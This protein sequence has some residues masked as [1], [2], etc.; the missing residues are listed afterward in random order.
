MK[1]VK[2]PAHS[3]DAF[4]VTS[5]GGLTILKDICDKYGSDKEH[6]YYNMDMHAVKNTDEYKAWV[7]ENNRTAGTVE[8]LMS[9][10]SHDGIPFD[11]LCFDTA[12]KTTIPYAAEI[13]VYGVEL[14]TEELSNWQA[15]AIEA[16]LD[17][18]SIQVRHLEYGGAEHKYWLSFVGD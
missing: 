18:I 11:V 5:E 13:P 6:N 12:P 8:G 17:D 9:E 1:L 10:L 7:A 3:I 16:I 4:L 15:A 14:G 2:Y